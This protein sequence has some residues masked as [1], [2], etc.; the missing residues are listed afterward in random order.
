[1]DQWNNKTYCYNNQPNDHR[2]LTTININN[3]KEFVLIAHEQ[4]LFNKDRLP[5]TTDTKAIN[6]LQNGIVENYV[7]VLITEKKAISEILKSE[8]YELFEIFDLK[9]KLEPEILKIVNHIDYKEKLN[10]NDNLGINAIIKENE[11]LKKKLNDMEE[12]LKAVN[13]IA[14]LF[15]PEN[16]E[17]IDN[18]LK[19]DPEKLIYIDP[20]NMGRINKGLG[21]DKK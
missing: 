17:R 16:M 5:Y 3:K 2:G 11:L 8:N 19:L 10:I 4:I 7:G 9:D 21:I 13:T 12:P 15:N 6:K 20:E 1:L 14:K 18:E